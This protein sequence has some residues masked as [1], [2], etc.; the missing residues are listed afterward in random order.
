MTGKWISRLETD[1]GRSWLVALAVIIGPTILIG[2][3][4][5]RNQVL[6]WGTPAL[7]FVPWWQ[8]GLR[9]FLTGDSPLWN[10][11]NGMG[12]PLL[13]NYQTAFFYPPNWLL[14]LFFKGWGASGL[15]WG[16]TF[17]AGLHL[18]WGGLGM[19]ILLRRLNASLL[20]QAV[21]GTAFALCGYW[22]GRLEFFSMIWAGAWIPWL[23]RYVDE[24]ASPVNLKA[25]IDHPKWFQP[26]LVFVLTMLL[27]AGH[28][29][30][31]W[32][33]LELAGVWLVAGTMLRTGWR[34]LLGTLGRFIAAVLIAVGV[35]A[36]QLIP[37]AEY[38]LQSQRA[39]T[40]NQELALTY[41]FW[42][43]R[44]ISLFAPDFFGNPGKGNFWGYASY[45]E[46]HAYLGVLLVLMGLGT[47][48]ILFTKR[49]T[50]REGWLP[51]PAVW[52]LWGVIIV[53]IVL[54][55][56][57]YTPIFPFLFKYVPSFNMFQAPA[58]SMI[59]LDFAL[60]ILGVYGI[61][62]WKYPTGRGLYWLRLGTAG[63]FAVALGAGLG[64]I[65]LQNVKLTFIQ[66][67]ALAGIWAFGTCVL[68]LL[69]QYR[70]RPF[71]HIAW[72]VMV[73]TWVLLDLLVAGW[74]LNPTVPASLYNETS[75]EIVQLRK[76]LSGQR[77]FFSQGDEYFVKFDRFLRFRDYRAYENWGSMKRA[78]LPNTNLLEGIAL[79]S[80][81]D[82]FVPE[83]FARWMDVVNRLPEERRVNLL[84]MMNVGAIEQVNGTS[85]SGV[86]FDAFT[87]GFP[88]AFYSC[89]E[90]IRPNDN[91]L[92]K[93]AQK[94]YSLTTLLVEGD[95]LISSQNC[96]DKPV[97]MISP[98]EA[99]NGKLLFDVSNKSDWLFISEVWY[100]GWT[101]VID[102]EE[103]PI[104]RANYLFM[105]VQIPVGSHKLVL[106][107]RPISYQVG[108]ILSILI[109][110]GL[111]LAILIRRSRIRRRNNHSADLTLRSL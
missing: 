81:F 23:L 7:Q 84:A 43:W 15:A 57:F 10:M 44:I 30:L 49:D 1:R 3:E 29:Q 102:G 108:S 93:M 31:S 19:A 64:W 5:I 72:P 32:Y 109:L 53:S 110:V 82:P 111:T 17:L 79:T 45:W 87:G 50:S 20:A 55:M 100:P 48:G 8:E 105:A 47:I 92:L 41:S 94:G 91:P 60:I 58:R 28:A 86:E 33:A 99:K 35:A 98:I 67:G 24:I 61:D 85:S 38:L 83:R 97:E 12:A 59:W 107:Y 16:F 42:P 71:W 6:F 101:A 73:Y 9:Q 37:T 54:A 66:A 56:G 36:V 63:A 74:Q 95:P 80:N 69:S 21:G 52:L 27:L 25:I 22:I 39:S 14:V 11:L 106:Q 26:R 34:E 18:I 103:V 68:G 89:V 75:R 40:V 46:D 62:R 78:L 96:S 70:N 77:I 65:F 2:R 4:L 90:V 13:A 88:A 51:K 104:Y 76:N